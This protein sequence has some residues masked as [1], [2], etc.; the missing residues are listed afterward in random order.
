M[1]SLVAVYLLGK[2]VIN[3]NHD[4]LRYHS[5]I[6][7]LQQTLSTLKDAET[8]Q[9]GYLLT[10]RQSYLQPYAAAEVRVPG[11]LGRLQDRAREGELSVRDVTRLSQLVDTKLNELRQTMLVRRSQGFP[12]AV[13]AVLTD[14]GKTAMDSIRI[15][16]AQMIDGQEAAFARAEQRAARFDYYRNVG[17][18]LGTFLSFAVLAWA[19]RRI[20]DES[21]KRER[22]ALEV[23]RQKDLLDVT[24]ASIGDAVIVT[25]IESRITFMNESAG[26]LTGWTSSQALRQPCARVFNIVNETSRQLVESPVDKAL[27]VGTIV[28]LNNH[29][30]LI[31]KDGSEIPIDHCSSPIKE[32]NGTIRGVVLIFRNSPER[33]RADDRFRALLESAP[34]AMVIVA[35]DGR[36]L[37]VNAQTERLFGYV[38]AEL[39]GAPVEKLMP[40]WLRDQHPRDGNGYFADSSVRAMGSGMELGGVRK[41]G[42]E[43]P[44]EISRCPLKTEEGNLISS[45]IRD[46]TERKN[47]V[48]KLRQSEERFRLIVEGAKDYVILALDP[49]GL[50]VSWNEGAQRIQGYSSEEII[51]RHFSCFYPAEDVAAGKPLRELE[52][53][54]REGTCKDE[55][56]RLRKDGSRFFADVVITTLYDATA[57]IRGFSKVTRDISERKRAEEEVRALTDSAL[58]HATQIEAANQD[59]EAFSYSVSH[60]L[61][62]PLRSIDG[63]SLALMEDYADR[64]DPTATGFLQR[65]RAATQRMAQLIDDL[66]S[67]ARVGRGEMR[68]DSVDLGEMAKAIITNL[69]KEDP[70]RVV[71]FVVEEGV[72]GHGDSRLL[73][74][75]LENLLGNAWKFTS[76]KPHARIELKADRQNGKT[77]YSIS[78]DGAG[79]DMAYAEKLFGIFQRLHAT[80]DFPGTG[81][82]LAIVQ[83]IIKRHSGE[84][85]AVGA[86]GKGATFSF[87]LKE[88][89]KKQPDP[90]GRRQLR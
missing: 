62:A 63:F 67:L 35:E 68:N 88:Y 12:A 64:L 80:I 22:A 34:D 33:K 15:Q 90:P 6:G 70:Q 79:F 1:L 24:L 13:A 27:R 47:A 38:R 81:V 53:A 56:W 49:Q 19:Y 46:I 86:E 28:G 87:T 39:L 3:A 40:Q 5:I 7:E 52:T 4:L 41:D 55:G 85:S 89:E 66:L 54:R 8:G 77:V 18:E 60:D 37:Q 72:V 84:I 76:K 51:G 9:R 57:E 16:I 44:I 71:D 21:A 23:I 58:R 29:T 36:I 82:G 50:I 48:E 73:Q 31:R 43:F 65:I 45:A 78:D 11:E 83:R 59:L 14:S 30:V 17:M 25:D 2:V 20:R 74:L 10:G 61:R 32:P 75:V 69:E 26:E 42:T